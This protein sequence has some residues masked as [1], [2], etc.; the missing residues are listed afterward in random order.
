MSPDRPK[1]DR[2]LFT[3]TWYPHDY[4]FVDNTGEDGDPLDCWSSSQ[5]PTSRRSSGAARSA[6]S[7][8][9]RGRRGRQ[10]HLQVPVADPVWSICATSTTWRS[11][12][13]SRVQHFFEVYKDP[14]PGK[15]V[16][17]AT[18]E[19]ATPPR[20]EVLASIALQG[21]GPQHRDRSFALPPEGDTQAE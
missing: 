21:I 4:G 14:E 7:H 18:W 2:M 9:R 3:S 1:L 12:T 17:G 13:G 10:A 20:S 6:C 15:S 8:D 16:E 5:K 19:A 11:S